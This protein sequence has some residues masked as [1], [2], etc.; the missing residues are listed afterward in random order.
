MNTY[1]KKNYRNKR[2]YG[3][4]PRR[5]VDNYHQP[6]PPD[7]ELIPLARHTLTK[8]DVE[9][10]VESLLSGTL[11]QGRELDRFE[12]LLAKLTHSDHAIALSSGTAALHAGLAC[13]K[14][15]PE[16]EVITS[17]LNDCSAAN[18]I[19][20]VGAK[21]VL[22]DCD[23]ET[24][25]MSAAAAK[26]AV[27]ENTKAILTNNFAGH[28][29]DMAQLREI[30][31]EHNLLL[32][33]D[34]SHGL[35]GKYRGHYVGNQADITCFSFLPNMAITTCEGGAVTTNNRTI[36]EWIRQFRNHGLV[37]DPS[38]DKNAPPV[39]QKVQFPGMNYM[40]CDVL[41]ALG[42]SQ[43]TRLDRHI[44]R[45][46]SIAQ[47]YQ[48][49]LNGTA[50]LK[51]PFVA[52]WADH[53][54]HLFPVKL[55]GALAKHRNDLIRDLR[56]QGVEAST[57]F[58]PLHQMPAYQDH[59]EAGKFPNAEAFSQSG[60][61]L[62]L[63]PDLSYKDIERITDQLI[64]LFGKYDAKPEPAKEEKQAQE[65]AAKP[66]KSQEAS[67]QPKSAA[68]SEEVKPDADTGKH[69][70]ESKEK[71]ANSRSKPATGDANA[72]NQEAPPEEKQEEKPS[73]GTKSRL[74]KVPKAEE[75]SEEPPKTKPKAKSRT[76]KS[77]RGR[78]AKTQVEADSEE[79]PEKPKRK[80]TRR[81]TK[82]TSKT[83]KD[84]SK[85]KTRRT[86]TRKPKTE[87][88]ADAK[89]DSK[90]ASKEAAT[91][92]KKS[93]SEGESGTSEA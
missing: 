70:K 6:T 63:F 75:S 76:T 45:R 43:L 88:P 11:I 83:E 41:A 28:P 44:E 93:K 7:R 80:T 38:K 64:K 66:E 61:C 14:L 20:L 13:L 12:S 71:E 16:D 85:P 89:K 90:A 55:S 57:N 15:E 42:R 48:Q 32:I 53:A 2:N 25:T 5:T 51:L 33:E 8:P 21:P 24:L 30:C 60:L 86:R 74:R 52:D 50:N 87:K 72:D 92:D 68:A 54:Y 59:N 27:N 62:P 65:S 91:S 40:L 31:V 10:V 3:G 56:H 9:A 4:R 67:S 46:R 82:T 1:R 19:K 79:K 81:T 58:A 18:M 84:E 23:A 47:V 73:K 77:T 69:A 37:N 22:V 35:G 36:A 39:P 49:K 26:A 78:Q 29:S 34:A 17:T